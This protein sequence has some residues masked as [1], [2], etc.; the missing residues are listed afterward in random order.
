MPE[1]SDEQFI[2]AF[3]KHF[4][5]SDETNLGQVSPKEV[6]TV[7]RRQGK[8]YTVPTESHSEGNITL[9]GYF[10]GHGVRNLVKAKDTIKTLILRCF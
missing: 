1:Q 10:G 2:H 4:L 3:K 9:L 8:A 6:A 7:W 5:W